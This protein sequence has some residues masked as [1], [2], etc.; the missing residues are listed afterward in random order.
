MLQYQHFSLVLNT[1][2]GFYNYK[3][4]LLSLFYG[5]LSSAWVVASTMPEVLLLV[6]RTD[7]RSLLLLQLSRYAHTLLSLES[8]NEVAS[9]PCAPRPPCAYRCHPPQP[10]RGAVQVVEL[11]V[12][13]T[14]VLN[15]CILLPC[16]LL[17]CFHLFLVAHGRTAYEWKQVRQGLRSP[18]ESLFDY[19]LVNNFALTLGV[20]PLLWLLPVRSGIEGNGIF[21]PEKHHAQHFR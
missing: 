18:S 13:I 17:L 5:M 21:F 2:I 20:Y 12:L 4:Y 16:A 14:F 3:F 8:G 15:V 6:Q 11:S 10:L 19:G 7:S 1:A 9:R